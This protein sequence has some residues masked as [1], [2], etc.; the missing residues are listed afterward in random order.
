MAVIAWIEDDYIIIGAVVQPLEKAGHRVDRYRTAAEALAAVDA[1]RRADLILFDVLIPPGDTE[2]DLGKYVGVE[3][4]RVLR[5]DLAVDVPAMAFT[6][7]SSP[8]IDGQLQNL[9]VA[10]MLTKPILPSELK[11]EV[12]DV[13]ASS[14]A[15][16][17]AAAPP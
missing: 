4:M 11:R 14:R 3:L 16:T 1:L 13:L 17:S 2:R 7:V 9:G 12:D 10:R 5:Q 6:V 8:A 15:V